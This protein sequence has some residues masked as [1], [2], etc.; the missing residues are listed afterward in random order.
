[1][2]RRRGCA[3]RTPAGRDD[4]VTDLQA[5][6]ELVHLL[7]FP[8]HGQEDDEVEDAEDE[9]KRNELDPRADRTA[10]EEAR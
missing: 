10:V 3:A 2:R 4:L 8:P 7:L 1:M 6:D 9:G 5:A